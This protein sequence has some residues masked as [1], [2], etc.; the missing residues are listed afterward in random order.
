M[1]EILKTIRSPK[2]AILAAMLLVC[3]S[4]G[5]GKSVEEYREE[6]THLREDFAAL[7]TQSPDE[8]PAEFERFENEVFAEVREFVSERD[9]V[10]FAGSE[11]D[12]DNKWLLEKIDEYRSGSKTDE[13]RAAILA[14][15]FERLGAIENKLYEIQRA[16]GE[17]A[18]KDENKRKL[19]E[20]LSGEEYRR[21]ADKTDQSIFARFMKWLEDWFR[22]LFPPREVPPQPLGIPN[23]GAFGYVLQFLLYGL[24]IFLVGYLIY[25]FGPKLLNRRR[26]SERAKKKE[27]VV[28]GEKIDAGVTTEDLF[29]EAERLVREGRMREALRKGYIALLFGLGERKAIGLAKH[30]TNRDYLRELTSAADLHKV[31]SG[32]TVQYERHWYGSAEAAEDDWLEFA[33]GYSEAIGRKRR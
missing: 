16:R 27:R 25:R 21:S 18:T 31:V 20:I 17:P 12:A 30:K 11:I 15:V 6:V 23:L 28:L 8:E 7:L 29:S 14:A 24:V 3:V 1:K 4:A 9:A 13:E 33:G 22:Y 10:S 5:L 32:L 26:D 19:S 2:T